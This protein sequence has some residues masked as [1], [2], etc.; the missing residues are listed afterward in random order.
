MRKVLLMIGVLAVAGC[1]GGPGE[2]DWYR[3]RPN[4]DTVQVLGVGTIG[5]LRQHFPQEFL[6]DS[7]CVVVERSIA[8]AD[9][10][11]AVLGSR[12]AVIRD[13]LH[14]LEAKY[15]QEGVLYDVS[16]SEYTICC[17]FRQFG[18]FIVLPASDFEHDYEKFRR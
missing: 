17:S 13:S 4:G 16:V 15:R 10:Q 9:S 14:A 7:L 8:H 5:E 3:Y 1:S 18:H 2:G 12:Y 6:A 11:A